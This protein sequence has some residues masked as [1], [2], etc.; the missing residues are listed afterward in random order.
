MPGPPEGVGGYPEEH[1]SIVRE[2]RMKI[3]PCLA[4]VLVCFAC[5]AALRADAEPKIGDAVTDGDGIL[6][7]RVESDLQDRPTRIRVLLPSKTEEGRRYRVLYVL[8]VEAGDEKRFGDGLL[9]VKKLGL[10]DQYGLICVQ[11]T[12]ARLPW[13]ADHATDPKIRQE[14]Y[15]LNEVVPFVE[16]R[17]PAVAKPEGRLLLGFSKS[18]W[19][20]FTL[21]LRHP[22]VFGKAAAWDAPLLMDAPGKYG[23]GEIFATKENFEKYRVTR[24]LEERA[25]KLGDGK[26]LAVLGYGGFRE[27]HRGAHAL[28]ERLKIEHEYADGPARRHEW[29]SGWVAE[30][31]AFLAKPAD[32]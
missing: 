13:Y 4:A 26:R 6:V 23:S 27:E 20:A 2:I 31:V 7:H 16:K 19:G 22:D 24:L 30:A 21:L 9:E 5:A 32:K 12:F 15:L 25:G 28:M 18:G 8:P 10:H 11:P 17:Y 29:H 14:S 3:L 1:R